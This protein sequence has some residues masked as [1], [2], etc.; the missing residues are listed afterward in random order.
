MFFILGNEK[1]IELLIQS[2]ANLDV[3]DDEVSSTAL[4][5]AVALGHLIEHNV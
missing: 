1:M 2:G 4:H 5:W 3:V